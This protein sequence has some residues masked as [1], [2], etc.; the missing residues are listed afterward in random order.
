MP[1]DNIASST[2]AFDRSS[3]FEVFKFFRV[4]FCIVSQM[5]PLITEIEYTVASGPNRK[6]SPIWRDIIDISNHS[7][8]KCV[9]VDMTT[10]GFYRGTSLGKAAIDATDSVGFNDIAFA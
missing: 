8:M 6:T 2:M 7:K 9:S 3:V 4:S 5:P 10:K 1:E